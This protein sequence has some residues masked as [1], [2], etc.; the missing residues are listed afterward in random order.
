MFIFTAAIISAS[1]GG[2]GGSRA[3]V[4]CGLDGWDY[5]CTSQADVLGLWMP[6]PISVVSGMMIGA[7][8]G[9]ALGFGLSRVSNR[10][11]L[12]AGLGVTLGGTLFVTSRALPW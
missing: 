9:G 4:A 10:A 11:Y 8:V 2:V 5:A 7:I 1:L 6:R 3:P 12:A